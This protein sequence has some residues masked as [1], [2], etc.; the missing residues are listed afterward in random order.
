ML[1]GALRQAAE[2][3]R[4]V[5]RTAGEDLFDTGKAQLGLAQLSYE[6]NA[7][8]EA[9]Q[10]AQDALDLG[11]I[12]KDAALQVQAALVLAQIEQA[13]GQATAA[14]QQLRALFAGLSAMVTPHLPL[15][16]RRIEAAQAGLAL[17]VGDLA[18]AERWSMMSAPLREHL[19]RLH[20]EQEAF[21]D[22][23]LLIAQGKTEG[24]LHLLE[25]WQIEA[26][27]LGRTRSEVESLMLMAR[28]ALAQER[29]LHATSLLREV[30]A[31]AQAEGYQRLFLDEGDEMVALLRVVWPTIRNERC[32]PYVRML[33]RAFAQHRLELGSTPV[34]SESVPAVSPSSLSPQEQRVLRL[35]AAGYSNPEIAEALVV[36]INTVKTQVHSI[37]QKLNV[38]SRKEARAVAHDQ[39]LF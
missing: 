24:A 37:Y 32:E 8:E 31:L 17:A 9:W 19:P 20:Q 1:Q 18:T 27:E 39:N 25:R 30:L 26:H 22:A 3:Y 33:L 34:P 29:L 11:T 14:G 2:L 5:L 36:S 6:W 7:L 13:R 28:A 10:G 4:E 23:R 35:L 21:I 12:L 38:K 15:L 16:Q